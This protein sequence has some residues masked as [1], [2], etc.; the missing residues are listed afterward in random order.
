M[1][2]LSQTSGRCHNCHWSLANRTAASFIVLNRG[3]E[4][5]AVGMFRVKG[6]QVVMTINADAA[7]KRK[8]QAAG[9]TEA[10]DRGVG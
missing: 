10:L 6:S 8:F 5:E 9:E 1:V 4:V 3:S 2:G 7:G